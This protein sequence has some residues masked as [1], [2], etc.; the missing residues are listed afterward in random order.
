[1]IEQTSRRLDRKVVFI[2]SG[3]L[4][5]KLKDEGP[6][7]FDPAGPQFDEKI[8]DLM[9]KGDFGGLFEFSPEFCSNAGECGH[10]SFVI[11]AG[12]FDRRK[13]KAEKLSYEGPFGVGYGICS[14][15]PGMIDP[16]RDFGRQAA[17]AEKKRRADIKA[18]E[19]EYVKL[20]RNSLENYIKTKKVIRTPD[21]LP[22]E[23]L[24]RR[25]GAFVSLKK[26]GQ[27]RGCIGTISPVRENL[28]REIIENAVSAAVRDPRFSPVR[29]DELDDLE[30]SVDVLDEPEHIDSPQQLDV[31]KYGVIVRKGGRTGLLLP[32]L[33][34]VDTIEEQISIAKQKAGIQPYEDVELSRF[35]VVRH[36]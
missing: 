33:E 18:G 11:M 24:D 10:R 22:P 6:Y 32:N 8:M 12:A 3:D 28:A 35:Q 5:H 26:D 7:G 29:E 30:Y 25:A 4:S 19:D 2:A 21:I 27:L 9:S 36:K 13:V 20:A 23:M 17:A 16:Q 34:G 14:F 1:L 31:K 15:Y